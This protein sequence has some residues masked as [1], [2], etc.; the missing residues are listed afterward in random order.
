MAWLVA[1]VALCMYSAVLSNKKKML[2]HN[3]HQPP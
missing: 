1:A 2:A 3:G